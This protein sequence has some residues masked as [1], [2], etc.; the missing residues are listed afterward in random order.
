MTNVKIPDVDHVRAKNAAKAVK[1]R[2]SQLGSEVCLNHAY[3]VVAATLGFKTWAVMKANLDGN[4]FTETRLP[5]PINNVSSDK[6]SKQSMV[7]WQ[8]VEIGDYNPVVMIHGPSGSKRDAVMVAATRNS[9]KAP[10]RIRGI[11]LGT[12]NSGL[13]EALSDDWS[14]C[15]DGQPNRA[16]FVLNPMS[17]RSAINIFDLPFRATKPSPSH[18]RRIVSFLGELTLL[19]QTTSGHAFLADAVAELY[20]H[21]MVREPLM[22][23]TGTVPQIDEYC[24][25]AGIELDE[26]CTSWYELAITLATKFQ[27][28]LAGVAWRHACPRLEHLMNVLRQEI[29]MD[30]YGEVKIAGE[31]IVDSCMRLLAIAIRAY[32]FFQRPT[33]MDLGQTKVEIIGIELADGQV[34][35]ATTLFYRLVFEASIMEYGEI[36]NDTHILISGGELL[37][38]ELQGLL[39]SAHEPDGPKIVLINDSTLCTSGIDRFVTSHIVAGCS[40]RASVEELCD[41]L[42]IDQDG[43]EAIHERLF[44]KFDEEK[45]E[46]FC[47]KKTFVAQR[48]GLVFIPTYQVEALAHLKTQS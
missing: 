33:A 34:T 1:S 9:Q 21:F 30:T 23:Q 42:K 27:S 48:E 14:R 26:K 6:N 38:D 31:R 37:P 12:S 16:M 41:R 47:V 36:Q 45:L 17:H 8:D 25:L 24:M 2:L 20:G 3:E 18:L 46:V 29:I 28:K 43:L 35:A 22:Y 39:E 40:T 10:R 32:P 7:R 13:D 4:Q 5:Y 19:S 44:G 11:V 15:L